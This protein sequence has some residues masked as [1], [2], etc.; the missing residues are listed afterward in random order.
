MCVCMCV[1]VSSFPWGR[2]VI[3]ARVVTVMRERE[4]QPCLYEMFSLLLTLED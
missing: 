1:Y 4:K 3:H 2:L